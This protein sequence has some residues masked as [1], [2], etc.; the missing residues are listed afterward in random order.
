[1]RKMYLL[2]IFFVAFTQW[3]FAKDI[4]I[5]VSSFNAGNNSSPVLA[6]VGDVIT[7][8]VGPSHP[9]AQLTEA[10]WNSDD[11][12][13][14]SGGFNFTS[15]SPN[16]SITITLNDAGTIIYFGCLNHG[17]G[18]MKGKISV[19]PST[20]IDDTK[21]SL[22]PE[23]SVYPNPTTGV[24]KF[25]TS[26]LYQVEVLNVLGVEL[27]ELTVDGNSVDL[28]NLPQGVYLLRFRK[29]G[30]VVVKRVIKK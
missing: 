9:T 4:T 15:T 23:F 6:N 3:V 27:Q 2:A 20:S 7:F 10:D 24:L 13:P 11:M 8:T 1:M 25:N 30:R 26:G 29:E 16:K 21:I 17:S 28:S 5:D 19:S 18:G 22:A 12:T 14:M